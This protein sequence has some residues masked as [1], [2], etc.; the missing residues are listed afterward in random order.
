VPDLTIHGTFWH[1]D[2]RGGVTS[3]QPALALNSQAFASLLTIYPAGA[4]PAQV[5][6]F[7]GARPQNSVLPA[8]IYFTYDFR[9][10]NALNLKVEGVDTEIRYNPRFGWGSLS[11]GLAATYKTRFDQQVGGGS[12]VFS[13]LNTTGFNSSFP[14]E[15][16][17]MRA[18][19][20]A[21]VARFGGIVYVNYTGK[22]QDWFSPVN[23]VI[24]N[25]S[26]V[27]IGGGD[28][29]PAF[30]TVDAHVSYD[31]GLR[32]GTQ[33]FLDVTNLFNR[34]PPF[35]NRNNIAQGLGYDAMLA[36][37]IGRVVAVG[38]RANL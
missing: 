16:L 20:G 25:S 4:T 2:F 29:I 32:R 38:V 34:T 12:P 11:T 23:P 19:F 18:D 7:A 3:P 13:V 36:S 28:H 31:I 1:N 22:Y 27:P 6:Q 17:D 24:V 14:S 33:I 35:L 26:R 30:T 9:N 37:P 10:Q 21:H 8:P 5:A 15:R